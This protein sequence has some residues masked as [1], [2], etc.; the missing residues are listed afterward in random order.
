MY[1]YVG[2]LSTTAKHTHFHFAKART[3]NR[4]YDNEL[5]RRQNDPIELQK[6]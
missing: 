6:A 3:Y 1:V 2:T 5:E 4:A